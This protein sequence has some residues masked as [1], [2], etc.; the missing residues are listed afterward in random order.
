M[1]SNVGWCGRMMRKILYQ[2]CAQPRR[3]TMR[4]LLTPALLALLLTF[5]IPSFANHDGDG[6]GVGC[7]KDGSSPFASQSKDAWNQTRMEVFPAV[8]CRLA[9][10]TAPIT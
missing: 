1:R 6:G 3:K 4:V 2:R 8:S 9:A 7:C 5:P 10:D